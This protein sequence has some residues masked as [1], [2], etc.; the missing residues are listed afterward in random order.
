MRVF[1]AV[2]E[3]HQL[4]R[5]DAISKIEMGRE[6]RL[7]RED[8]PVDGRQVRLAV[9]SYRGPKG[10]VLGYPPA[11]TTREIAAAQ[12]RGD[13]LVVTAVRIVDIDERHL[14]V[15]ALTDS[16]FEPQ[17]EDEEAIASAI[18]ERWKP[19]VFDAYTKRRHTPKAY[20]CGVVGEQHYQGAVRNTH[21]GT[22]V[23]LALEPDNRFDPEAV[24]VLNAHGQRIGYLARDNFAREWVLNGEEV[25]ALVLAVEMREFLNVV[26]V[27]CLGSA[28]DLLDGVEAD[29]NLTPRYSAPMPAPP[30]EAATLSNMRS[31]DDESASVWPAFLLLIA[32]IAGAAFIIAVSKNS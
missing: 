6:L 30:M 27:V 18:E 11:S 10:A 32:L 24:V 19:P 4:A 7:R 16:A 26:L 9:C 15:V 22:F 23:D 13:C 2:E 25:A 21:V 3:S 14:L 17:S 28:Q 29:G 20:P 1:F 31:R 12:K 5:Q 8:G